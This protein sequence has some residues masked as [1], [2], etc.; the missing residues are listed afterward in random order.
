MLVVATAWSG[1][2]E[3]E[4]AEAFCR[5]LFD[6]N[7]RCV[8]RQLAFQREQAALTAPLPDGPEPMEASPDPAAPGP[9]PTIAET[10][11]KEYRSRCERTGGR[12]VEGEGGLALGCVAK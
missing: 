5:Q 8:E 10:V 11:L 7:D 3:R 4:R 9:S 6:M 1:C 12:F 2:A